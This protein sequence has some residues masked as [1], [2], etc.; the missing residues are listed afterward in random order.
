MKRP[1]PG[2]ITGLPDEGSLIGRAR[3][4]REAGDFTGAIAAFRQAST[5][6]DL[7]VRA[8]ALWQLGAIFLMELGDP[9]AAIAPLRQAWELRHPDVGP[10]AGLDL[11]LAYERAGQLSRAGEAFEWVRDLNDPRYSSYAAIALSRVLLGAGETERARRVLDDAAAGAD[12]SWAALAHRI[13]GE[14]EQALGNLAAAQSQ[15]ELALQ[16]GVEDAPEVRVTLARVQ[17]KLGSEGEARKNYEAALAEGV[18]HAASIRYVLASL[19]ARSAA[20]S[21]ALGNYELVWHAHDDDFNAGRT[22]LRPNA[23][24]MLAHLYKKAGDIPAARRAAQYAA[25]QGSD[26]VAARAMSFLAALDAADGKGKAARTGF[27]KALHRAAGTV[28]LPEARLG[29]ARLDEKEGNLEAALRGYEQLMKSKDETLKAAATFGKGRVLAKLGDRVGARI[30][31]QA[32][33]DGPISQGLR[34]TVTRHLKVLEEGAAS[35]EVAEHPGQKG[36]TDDDL[37]D[38][39]EHGE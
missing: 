36:A 35:K 2:G 15:Y 9:Q 39:T 24:G 32:A 23:A 3:R 13:L 17:A 6:P 11:G 28:D 8:T 16:M 34:E 21:E 33:L 37:D 10:L 7:I 22:D 38:R 30:S 31:Y 26:R 14:L 18:E 29:M 1:E 5:H 20:W 19:Q 12:R 4:L 25:E 27:E